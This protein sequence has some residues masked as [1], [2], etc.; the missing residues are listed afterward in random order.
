MKIRVLHEV[1]SFTT[2]KALPIHRVL[3]WPLSDLMPLHILTSQV[4]N[5]ESI[6]TLDGLS[7]QGL[8]ALHCSLVSLLELG[9]RLLLQGTL[10]WSGR[11][12]TYLGPGVVTTL[13]LSLLLPIAF[14]DT[15]VVF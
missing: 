4:S 9:S 12:Y 13:T 2:I 8:V 3:H 15:T 10:D 5:L 11:W 6:G 14:H 7:L 1:S